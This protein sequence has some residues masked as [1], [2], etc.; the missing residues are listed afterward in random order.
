M[1]DKGL[2]YVKI[3]NRGKVD[4]PL[5]QK[6][7]EFI[8]FLCFD[9]QR[10]MFYK[11]SPKLFKVLKKEELGENEE[12]GFEFT[13][14]FNIFKGRIEIRK[15]KDLD[16]FNIYFYKRR[17]AQGRFEYDLYI[18]K[19][20]IILENINKA[21]DFLIKGENQKIATGNVYLLK[22]GMVCIIKKYYS[23]VKIGVI[24]DEDSEDVEEY[25]RIEDIDKLIRTK[26]EY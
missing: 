4:I 3:E 22:N 17:P 8:K 10:G 5:L 13:V 25:I 1:K 26:E 21:F 7:E 20:D 14:I 9:F 16:Y 12:F 18:T 19:K 2:R 11:L 15:Q 6:T 24:Y 23:N